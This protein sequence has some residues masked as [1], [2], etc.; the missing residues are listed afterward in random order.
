MVTA[1]NV[2]IVRLLV[3][4]MS[5]S[6]LTYRRDVAIIRNHFLNDVAA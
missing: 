2:H 3:S 4:R 5:D 6:T 1:T